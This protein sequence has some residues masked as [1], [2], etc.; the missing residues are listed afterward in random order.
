MLFKIELSFQK[1]LTIE[2]IY[3]SLCWQF[4]YKGHIVSKYPNVKQIWWNN[5]LYG[6]MLI[7]YRCNLSYYSIPGVDIWIG[8]SN[9]IKS[10]KTRLS[11]HFYVSS[12]VKRKQ[13]FHEYKN[14]TEAGFGIMPIYL[15]E[16]AATHTS[17]SWKIY[18]YLLL[19]KRKLI[20]SD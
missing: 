15:A 17:T 6:V 3:L 18:F 9:C 16:S 4:S 11:F 20:E 13:S 8:L 7:A 14:L 12:T 19:L 1:L 5:I 2:F 10:I